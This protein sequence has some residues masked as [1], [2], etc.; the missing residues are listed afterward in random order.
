MVVESIID[1]SPPTSGCNIQVEMLAQLSAAAASGHADIVKFL[2]GQSRSTNPNVEDIHG[3][4]LLYIAASYR[5][6]ICHYVTLAL[7]EGQ[8]KH[9][10]SNNP[11]RS[12]LV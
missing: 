10:S 1:D 4:T 7:G 3:H 12:C 6:H 8:W 2:P 9:C 11:L 5:T